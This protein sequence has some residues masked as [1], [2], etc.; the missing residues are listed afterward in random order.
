MNNETRVGQKRQWKEQFFSPLWCLMRWEDTGLQ[1][2][3]KFLYKEWK[4]PEKRECEKQMKTSAK[5]QDMGQES[6]S[7][8]NVTHLLWNWNQNPYTHDPNTRH[9]HLQITMLQFLTEKKI[10]DSQTTTIHHSYCMKDEDEEK[11]VDK[12]WK[13]TDEKTFP[14]FLLRLV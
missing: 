1:S 14:V 8:I 10:P 4:K 2:Q 9:R 5:S 7:T 6:Q 11:R 3:P 13:L 12:K